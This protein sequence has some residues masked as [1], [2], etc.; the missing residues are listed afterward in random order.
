[1]LGEEM[2]GGCSAAP[3][4]RRAA[5]R[6]LVTLWILAAAARALPRRLAHLQFLYRGRS[7]RPA[8]A[9][10]GVVGPFL[11]YL[12]RP[13]LVGAVCRVRVLEQGRFD[14]WA[15]GGNWDSFQKL[16]STMI[17]PCQSNSILL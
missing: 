8:R 5:L 7:R 6:T 12:E 9:A 17:S 13:N 4:S 16:L 14:T 1:M 11:V 3:L 15:C 10:E 2:S